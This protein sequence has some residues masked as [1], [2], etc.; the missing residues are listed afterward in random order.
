[1]KIFRLL[2]VLCLLLVACGEPPEPALPANP[3]ARVTVLV[4]GGLGDSCVGQDYDAIKTGCPDVDLVYVA[5]H[6]AYKIDLASYLDENPHSP[7]VAVIAHSWGTNQAAT[8]P[9][10]YRCLLDPVAFSG[11]TITTPDDGA[12]VD[13]F[14]RQQVFG[15]WTATIKGNVTTVQKVPGDHGSMPRAPE[16]LQRIVE[17]I[18]AM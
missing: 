5:D 18:N 1:M 9:A 17:R 10:Q 12:I 15:P 4:C 14:Y 6:D 16:V 3:S 11:A 13:V 8:I 7:K 2:S